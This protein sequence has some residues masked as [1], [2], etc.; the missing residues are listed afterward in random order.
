MSPIFGLKYVMVFIFGLHLHL[1]CGVSPNFLGWAPLRNAHPH[2]PNIEYLLK[3]PGKR[4]DP[5]PSQGFKDSLGVYLTD[6][7]C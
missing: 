7:R 4:I 5:I 3:W 2:P 1:G 6:Q